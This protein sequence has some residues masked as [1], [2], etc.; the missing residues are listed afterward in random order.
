[1]PARGAT[2]SKKWLVASENLLDSPAGSR[3]ISIDEGAVVTA[4]KVSREVSGIQWRQIEFRGRTGWARE[5]YLEDYT[6]RFPDNEVLIPHQTP[7]EED[8]AQYMNLPGESGVKHNMCGQLCA[9]F[10]ME[11]DIESFIAE[12]KVA[13]NN[14]YKK[15]LAGGRDAPTG[16]DSVRSMFRPSP[17][18]AKEGEVLDFET[19]LRDPIT[20]RPVISPGSLKRLLETHY[21][22]A[23][24]RIKPG[25]KYAGR[26][27]GQGIGHWVVLDKITPN[28]ALSGAGGWVEIYNPFPNKRQEYTYDE[29]MRSFSGYNGIWVKRK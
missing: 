8:A 13:A 17:Y 21:L 25:D 7:D 11:V 3:L 27:S 24:V 10:I 29:F 28:G 4:T 2:V 6:D 20:N 1:M 9:A 14:Y 16:I 12:W 26:L 15:A 19:A 23:G 5:D 18:D 22:V